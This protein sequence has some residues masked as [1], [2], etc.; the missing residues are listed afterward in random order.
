MA[1]HL[2]DARTLAANRLLRPNYFGN[3]VGV[4]IGKKYV[5]HAQT[6]TDCIRVYVVA[7]LDLDD[8]S[9]AAVVPS[10]FLDVPTDIIEVGHFGWKGHPKK[11]APDRCVQPGAPIRVKTDAP[12]VNSGFTGTLGARLTGRPGE[13]YILGCN[14]VLAVNGRVPPE[15]P[16]V[17]AGLVS[18]LRNFARVSVKFE[19]IKRS[20]TNIVDCAAAMLTDPELVRPYFPVDEKKKEPMII[21]RSPEPISPQLGVRVKK[22]GAVTQLTE[23][24]IV[25][26]DAELYVEYSFGT[27][28]FGRQV[29]IDAGK[30]KEFAAQGDSGSLVVDSTAQQATGLLFAASG[31]YAIACPMS[32]VLRRLGLTLDV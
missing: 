21:L 8:L 20:A 11:P 24:T 4:G 5:D 17:S 6:P 28:R 30:G 13:Y 15:T 31:R 32:E 19:P 18:D 1:Q 29:I 22:Y 27:F 23:G 16:V 14:H 10:S 12:N 7:K 26:I 3:V 25:D 9:P 2:E